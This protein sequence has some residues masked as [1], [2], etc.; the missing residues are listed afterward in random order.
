MVGVNDIR[1]FH[2]ENL[3][4]NKSHYSMAARLMKGRVVTSLQNHGAKVHFNQMTNDEGQ[5]IRYGV[6]EMQ[7]LKHDLLYWETLVVSSF[8]QRPVTILKDDE[9]I[10]EAQKDNLA[11]ALAL[12]ALVSKNNCAETELFKNIVEIPH[13]QTSRLFELLDKEDADEIVNENLEQFRDI[14]YPVIE[15][16]FH[17]VLSISGGQVKLRED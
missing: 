1:A 12:A 4:T 6:V 11:S 16:H 14:Y 2:D 8:M 7:D 5:I 17:E 13:Y 10:Q 15:Q 3:R 9:E